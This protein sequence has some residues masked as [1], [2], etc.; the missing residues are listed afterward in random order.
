MSAIIA[1]ALTACTSF[2]EPCNTY[3]IDTAPTAKICY[4]Q[5]QQHESTFFKLWE[6]INN[7]LPLKAWLAGQNIEEEVA[8]LVEVR[9]NCVTV[10]EDDIP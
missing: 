4:T 6:D 8:D 3:Y 5:M 1:L 10:E 9:F 2:T 7:P